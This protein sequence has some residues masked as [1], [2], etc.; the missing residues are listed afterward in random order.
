MENISMNDFRNSESLLCIDDV[1]FA[2]TYS[3]SRPKKLQVLQ[4]LIDCQLLERIVADFFFF[5]ENDGRKKE[6]KSP[7]SGGDAAVPP[8]P[9]APP[10]TWARRWLIRLRLCLLLR[11]CRRLRS[12][13]A[14]GR[15]RAC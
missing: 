12:R 11:W 10:W 2:G 14:V 9:A 8:P 15:M 1:A 7:L 13:W 3:N 5:H 6:F 4:L